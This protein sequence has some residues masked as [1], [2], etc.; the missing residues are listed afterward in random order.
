MPQGSH[1]E[2]RYHP[3]LRNSLYQRLEQRDPQRLRKLH[4]QAAIWLLAQRRFTEAIYQFGRARDLDAVLGIVDRHGFELLR[5]GKVNTL[6]DVLDEVAGHAGNDS[7]TL[8]VTEASTVMVTNDIAQAC[9]C[10]RQLYGLQRRQARPEQKPSL[11]E[12]LEML[13]EQALAVQPRS[14]N[15][16]SIFMRLVGLAFSQSQGHLRRYLEDM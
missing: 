3:A 15:D 1:A 13:V 8:A 14:N 7:F 10:L 5:E 2:Y 12:L 9:Q 11:E 6:V 16:L 4:R